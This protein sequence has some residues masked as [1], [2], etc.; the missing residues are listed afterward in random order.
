MHNRMALKTLLP[1]VLDL[2]REAFAIA[3][4]IHVHTQIRLVAVSM[5]DCINAGFADCRLQIVEPFALEP[6]AARKRRNGIARNA[7]HTK[8]AGE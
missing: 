4:A 8:L 5:F 6:E 1:V 2:N 7:L 3:M